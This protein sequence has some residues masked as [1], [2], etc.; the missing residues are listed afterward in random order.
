MEQIVEKRLAPPIHHLPPPTPGSIPQVHLSSS[1]SISCLSRQAALQPQV[2]PSISHIPGA[3]L[4]L[5]VGQK[6]QILPVQV[7]L[8]F[9]KCPYLDTLAMLTDQYFLN[10][11]FNMQ[12]FNPYKATYGTAVYMGHLSK[13]MDQPQCSSSSAAPQCG[14]ALEKSFSLSVTLVVWSLSLPLTVLS[15]E[16]PRCPES[17]W[18]T[19]LPFSWSTW[20]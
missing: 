8:F 7:T 10:D 13:W 5:L 16:A 19:S 2:F 3:V 11:E 1:R 6:M 9:W 14:R 18:S 17:L 12:D 15:Q 4:S 20:D